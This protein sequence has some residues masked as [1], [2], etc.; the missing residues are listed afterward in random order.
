MTSRRLVPQRGTWGLRW[1]RRSDLDAG[2]PALKPAQSRL[3]GCFEGAD[4]LLD[5]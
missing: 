4:V 3:R 2:R 1:A 5:L